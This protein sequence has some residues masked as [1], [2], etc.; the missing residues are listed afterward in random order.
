MLYLTPNNFFMASQDFDQLHSQIDTTVHT[1]GPTGKTTAAGLNAL[2]HRF[3]SD[4]SSDTSLTADQLAALA[5]AANPSATNPYVTQADLTAI[6]TTSG[7]GTAS[8]Y[9]QIASTSTTRIVEVPV[10]FMFTIS[11]ETPDVN[12]A[13]VS[14]QVDKNTR[15]GSRTYGMPDQ[16][17]TQV[18][19]LLL[20]L[21]AADLAA[22]VKLYVNTMPTTPANPSVLGLTIQ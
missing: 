9:L 16:T 17:L 5:T 7:Q 11:A 8:T 19:A 10:P 13:A 22:G 18:N 20:A 21:T 14:Y 6:T 15:T 3:V 4:L 2:L 1:N 12:V